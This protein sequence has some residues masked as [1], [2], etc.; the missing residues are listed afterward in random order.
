M[1]HDPRH[2]AYV[3]RWETLGPELERIRDQEI[4]EADT[5]A[6]IRMFDTAFRVA[7]RDLPL[8]ESSGLWSGRRS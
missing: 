5:D 8:R 7:L 2:V 4:R 3:R 1:E 6:A